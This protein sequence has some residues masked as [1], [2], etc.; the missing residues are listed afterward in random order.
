MTEIRDSRAPPRASRG[1]GPAI[2]Y[3]FV[4]TAFLVSA[5]TLSRFKDLWMDEVLAVSAASLPTPAAV[6]SAIWRG[7]EFSPPTYHLLLHA[8]LAIPHDASP[9]LI[10]RL[11]SIV[12]ALMTAFCVVLLLRRDLRPLPVLVAFGLT[13]AMGLF[14]FAVQARQYAILALLQI[15]ALYLWKEIDQGQRRWLRAGGLWLA[16]SLSVSLHFYGVV[17]IAT[18]VVAEAAFVA[19]GRR[20]RPVVMAPIL[21]TLPVIA[22]WYPLAA[23]LSAFNEA[24][25]SGAAYYGRPNLSSFT[26][27]IEKIILGG[28]GGLLLLFAAITIVTAFVLSGRGA[29]GPEGAP[30]RTGS[31]RE[32]LRIAA[33]AI[34][35]ILFL[36]FGF[37]VL[38][39]HSFQPRYAVGASLFMPIAVAC[40]MDRLPTVASACMVPCI[41]IVLILDPGFSQYPYQGVAP[42]LAKEVGDSSIPIVVADGAL[43]LELRQSASAP[44]RS[45]LVYLRLPAGAPRYDPT[46]DNQVA[47]MAGIQKDI[48]TV[49]ADRFLEL[50]RRFLVVSGLGDGANPLVPFLIARCALGPAISEID[51]LVLLR[52]GT[53]VANPG[54]APAQIGAPVS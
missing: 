41:L 51:G 18:V 45:R 40:L 10:V 5:L 35:S 21:A 22:A 20:L 27:A 2:A 50:N 44:I 8:I 43:F 30:Q 49:P 33:A 52:G 3:A 42:Y 17:N 6:V 9:N 47:I 48:V 38:I 46:N 34:L 31:D 19:R 26:Q 16:L 29:A 11:P 53:D 1:L 36:A 12:A 25:V 37:A 23:H 4:A 13:L 14:D 24:N 28:Q 54:S 15:V 39:T 32:R 7:A